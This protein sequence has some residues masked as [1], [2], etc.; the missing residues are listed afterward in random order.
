MQYYEDRIKKVE[1]DY[2]FFS[3][4]SGYETTLSFYFVKTNRLTFNLSC[5]SI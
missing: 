3:K 4:G 5:C 2:P 1:P